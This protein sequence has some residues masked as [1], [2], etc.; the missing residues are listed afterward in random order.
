MVGDHKMKKVMKIMNMYHI[1]LVME[2]LK[3]LI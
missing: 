2:L 3:V 1:E